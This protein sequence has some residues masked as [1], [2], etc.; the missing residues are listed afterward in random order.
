MVSIKFGTDGWRGIIAKDFTFRNVAL[1]SQGVAD[2]VREEGLGAQ[3][4]V[5]GYDTRFASEA[6]AEQVAQVLTG[7]GIKAYLANKACP[8]PVITYNVIEHNSAG[9]IIITASHNPPQWNGFKFRPK[10]SGSATPQVTAYLDHAIKQA[11]QTGVKS[12]D[13]DLARKDGL[14]EYIDPM[15]PYLQK[16]ASIVD[17][18][19]ISDSEM[20]IVTD[21]MYGAGAG[22][23]PS[24]LSER[25]KS[26]FEL[27]GKRNPCFPGISQPEPIAHNL[28]GLSKTVVDEAAHIGLALDADADRLGIIDENGA[29]VTPLQI[30]SLLALYLLEVQGERGALVKTQTSTDMI[31]RLGEIFNVPVFET[32]VGFKYVAPVMLHHK[33]LIG[34]EESGGYAFRGHIPDR[35]GILSGLILLEFMAKSGK[36]ISELVRY[37]HDKV[38]PHSYQ[39]RDVQLSA[40]TRERIVSTIYTLNPNNIGENQVINDDHMDG[41]RFRFKKGWVVIRFS[42]T[43]PLLRLYAEADT[44]IGVERILDDTISLLD[45]D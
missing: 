39:R 27:H 41:R 36:S 7:N 33:A 1:A 12:M 14:V 29:F 21:A 25:K 23:F 45:L 43:E 30:F 31:F 8:T 4:I 44:A 17:L 24:L 10:N 20:D 3:G 40:K 34:G 42:G 5:I 22:Y 32:P 37:L 13:I 18:S 35:D 6:F 15:A 26:V 11:S 9:G 2:Y 16:I 28:G 38:G 19:I